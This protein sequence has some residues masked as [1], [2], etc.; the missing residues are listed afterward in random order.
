[1]FLLGGFVVAVILVGLVVGVHL[2]FPSIAVEGT[3]AFD[4]ASRVYNYV[5]GR[6]WRWL[7]YTA[8]TVIYGAI[9]YLFFG[10]LLFFTLAITH[11]AAGAWV[12]EAAMGGN[13][14]EA[15]F[16]A[17][18]FGEFVKPMEQTA[19]GTSG[20]LTVAAWLIQAWV[21][22]LVGLLPAFAISYYFSAHT[23]VYLLLRRAADGTGIEDVYL[24]DAEFEHE[25]AA[26]S[27]QPPDQ[28]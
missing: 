12:G 25:P 2:L 3:D 21:R 1:L 15:M 9:T 14:F 4:A 23:W 27:D 7:F 13:R 24:T 28:S 20:S 5:L 17:P 22:L 10:L 8:V 6:P 19:E 18:T 26:E 16:P 11:W